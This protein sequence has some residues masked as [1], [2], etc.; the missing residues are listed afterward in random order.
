MVWFFGISG[1]VKVVWFQPTYLYKKVKI[2][3]RLNCKLQDRKLIS[4]RKEL[5][6]NDRADTN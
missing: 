6:D 4:D 2:K 1:D 3:T 5:E